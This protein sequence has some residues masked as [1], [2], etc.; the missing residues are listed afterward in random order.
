[1]GTNYQEDRYV[2]CPFYKR[3]N[4]LEIKCEGLCGRY[5]NNIFAGKRKKDAFKEEFCTGYYWNCPLYRA[6]EED[7]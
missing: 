2:R 7:A 4:R 3:E 5:T 6:L 1:M